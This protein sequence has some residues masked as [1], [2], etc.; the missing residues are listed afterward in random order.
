MHESNGHAPRTESQAEEALTGRPF[1]LGYRPAWGLWAAQSGAGGRFGDGW[2]HIRDV[3]RMLDHPDVNLPY[4]YYLSGISDV[5]FTVKAKDSAQAQ[6]GYDL[7]AKLWAEW[8]TKLQL[9]YDFGWCGYELAYEVEKG[10]LS[11]SS[12]L[13]LHPLDCWA[14]TNCWLPCNFCLLQSSSLLLPTVL[15][16]IA[17]GG[18]G[19]GGGCRVAGDRQPGHGDG[20]NHSIQRSGASF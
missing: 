20:R 6:E 18:G 12:L 13:D 14:L 1:T 5:K 3:D 8:L 9:C 2:A 11:F 16:L 19:P 10:Y 17:D 4:G 7:L 15:P